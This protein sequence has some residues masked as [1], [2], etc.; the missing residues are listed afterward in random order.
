MGRAQLGIPLLH[1]ALA[2]SWGGRKE[3]GRCPCRPDTPGLLHASLHVVSVGLLG[4][5][6]PDAFLPLF[7]LPR[8]GSVSLIPLLPVKASQGFSPDVGAG[9]MEFTFLFVFVFGHCRPFSKVLHPVLVWPKPTR[10]PTTR[11]M[12]C[13]VL[14]GLPTQ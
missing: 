6:C 8:A 11:P 5:M 3:V 9:N 10:A 13:F 7:W 4:Q 12:P 1:M 14:T 2:G